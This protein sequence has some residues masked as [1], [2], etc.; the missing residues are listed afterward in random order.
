M[1]RPYEGQE[2]YWGPG[3]YEDP[4]NVTTPSLLR[5]TK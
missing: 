1:V 2:H 5:E 4:S 3:P